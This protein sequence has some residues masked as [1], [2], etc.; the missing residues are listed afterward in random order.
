VLAERFATH[1]AAAGITLTEPA[2][3]VYLGSSDI[4]NVSTLVPAIHPFVAITAP[5]ESDHTPEFAAAAAAPRA[6]TTMLAAARA[7]ADTT[8]DLLTDPALR[9]RSQAEFRAPD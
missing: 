8:V 7:L 1:L 4:G 6:R 3:G 2:P 9:E 5:E